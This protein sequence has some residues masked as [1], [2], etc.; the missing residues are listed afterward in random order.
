MIRLTQSSAVGQDP[1]TT[2]TTTDVST[3]DRRRARANVTPAR[4]ER[5]R[6]PTENDAIP[7]AFCHAGRTK[8]NKTN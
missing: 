6:R 8:N 7:L 2:T 1:T 4:K 3:S 5:E